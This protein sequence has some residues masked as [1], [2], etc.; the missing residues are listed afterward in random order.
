MKFIWSKKIKIRKYES[1]AKENKIFE[2]DNGGACHRKY[3][4]DLWQNKNYYKKHKKNLFIEQKRVNKKWHILG[5]NINT[6]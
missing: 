1:L 2:I 4:F 3:I 6:F 5:K